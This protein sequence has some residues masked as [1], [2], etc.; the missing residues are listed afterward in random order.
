MTKD[1]V[2]DVCLEVMEAYPNSVWPTA[3]AGLI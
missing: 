1:E 3:D 2:T